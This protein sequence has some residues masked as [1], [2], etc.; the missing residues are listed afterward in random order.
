MPTDR[1]Y[2]SPAGWLALARKR[3]KQAARV[4]ETAEVVRLARALLERLDNM[5]TEQFSRGEERIEREALRRAL[6]ELEKESA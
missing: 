2:L 4:D 3:Y 1:D 5:T 6:D